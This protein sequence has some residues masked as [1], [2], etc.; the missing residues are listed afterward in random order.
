[1][2]L[3]YF[4]TCSECSDRFKAL[5]PR[6]TLAGYGDTLAA[7]NAPVREEDRTVDIVVDYAGGSQ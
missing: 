3:K 7:K 1:M 4:L 2:V 6:L 5:R